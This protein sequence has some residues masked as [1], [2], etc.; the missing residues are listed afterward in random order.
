MDYT[1]QLVED[2]LTEYASVANT[3]SCN[4]ALKRL[5]MLIPT[6]KTYLSPGGKLMVH[7]VSIQLSLMGEDS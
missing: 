5:S 3:T 2:I 1:R 7:N 6:L 4:H